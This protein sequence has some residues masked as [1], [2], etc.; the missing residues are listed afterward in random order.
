[1]PGL[2]AIV[3]LDGTP[4]DAKV[5]AR[6]NAAAAHRGSPVATHISGP[7]AFAY[8]SREKGPSP[9]LL[10]GGLYGRVSIV[11]SGRLY[12]QRQLAEAT[13]ANASDSDAVLILS[14]YR[15]WGAGGVSRLDGDFAFVLHDAERNVAVCARDALGMHPLC[16][17]FDGKRLVAASEPR[18]VLAAG[19]PSEVCEESIAAY[20]AATRHLYGGPR[21]FYKNVNRVEPGH[22][23]EVDSRGARSKQYW[24]L[25]P[26]RKIDER[27]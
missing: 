3:N 21:T 11:L 9:N 8:L 23:L 27:Y 20:L 25:D 24:Q 17:A 12:G 4:V 13:G 2:S 6:C 15:R 1:M 7:T 18:Q 14:A 16:Y 10:S 26:N 22:L 5:L 19:V